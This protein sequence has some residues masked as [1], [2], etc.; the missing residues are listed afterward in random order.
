MFAKAQLPNS[1]NKAS[2]AKKHFREG[3]TAFEARIYE[4]TPLENI[5]NAEVQTDSTPTFRFHWTR[6]LPGILIYKKCKQLRFRAV[7]IDIS[8]NHLQAGKKHLQ[9]G[10][11]CPR[12]HNGAGINFGSPLSSHSARFDEG[13]D[14]DE[15]HSFFIEN[16]FQSMRYLFS[17]AKTLYGS[18]GGSRTSDRKKCIGYQTSTYGKVHGLD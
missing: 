8:G 11:F 16:G 7:H 15:R 1:K 5:R 6:L 18:A 2:D 14:V 13:D 12:F 10:Y 4:V 9:V 3:T 17:H